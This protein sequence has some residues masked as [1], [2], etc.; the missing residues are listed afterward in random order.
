MPIE[1][2]KS[3]FNIQHADVV[4]VK[5][6]VKCFRRTEWADRQTVDESNSMKFK[7]TFVGEHTTYLTLTEGV[8]TFVVILP[9]ENKINDGT[10]AD[11]FSKCIRRSS[12][13]TIT[14]RTPN[15]RLDAIYLF[16]FPNLPFGFHAFHNFF[17][18]KSWKYFS[19]RF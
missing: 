3:S 11:S 7:T 2:Y 18:L 10:T 15:P 4:V 12:K 9:N 14:N 17:H 13:T 16:S 5:F 19:T 6:L 1:K 8:N